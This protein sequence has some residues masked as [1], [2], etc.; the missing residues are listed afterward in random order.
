MFK[1]IEFKWNAGFDFVEIKIRAENGKLHCTSSGTD[2]GFNNDMISEL[3]VDTFGKRMLEMVSAWNS[4]Y[5]GKGVYLDEVSW[6]V[7]CDSDERRIKSSGNNAYPHNWK[8]FI[9]MLS[10]VAGE[11]TVD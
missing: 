3:S 9:K 5:E 10:E 11:I 4:D 6:S 1:S 7:I 8:M 2:C